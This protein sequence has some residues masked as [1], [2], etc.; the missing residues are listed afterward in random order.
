MDRRYLAAPIEPGDLR[1]RCGDGDR[2][3]NIDALPLERDEK[4]EEREIV[5]NKLHKQS[6]IP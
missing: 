3:R 2:R 4:E 1:D 6:I 5:R